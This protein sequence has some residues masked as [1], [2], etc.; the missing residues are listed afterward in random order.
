MKDKSFNNLKAISMAQK[1]IQILN[2]N[3]IDGFVFRVDM[4]LRP[5]G[6]SGALVSSQRQFIEYLKRMQGH[7]SAM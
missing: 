1:I 2:Q 5:F 6:K 7:G 4:R 3:T